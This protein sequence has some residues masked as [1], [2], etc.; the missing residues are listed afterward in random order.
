MPRG[1]WTGRTGLRLGRLFMRLNLLAL[2]PAQASRVVMV[3]Y[4]AL[5]RAIMTASAQAVRNG[6]AVGNPRVDLPRAELTKA[7]GIRGL[8]GI[9]QYPQSVGLC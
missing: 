8:G 2:V 4:S 9:P 5:K 3:A 1:T 6:V 7:H